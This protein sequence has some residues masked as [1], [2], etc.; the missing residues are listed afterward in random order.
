MI[1]VTVYLDSA[2]HKSRSKELARLVISNEGPGRKPGLWNYLVRT[3]TGRKKEDLD[4]HVINRLG[5]LEDIPSDKHHVWYLVA[6][7]LKAVNY[8]KRPK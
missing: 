6:E 2:I 7:A 1:I 8:D 5:N 4:K 3:F